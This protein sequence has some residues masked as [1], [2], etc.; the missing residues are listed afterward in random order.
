[1]A[2]KHETKKLSSN[3]SSEEME[4]RICPSRP[5]KGKYKSKTK[6]RSRRG[7]RQEQPSFFKAQG[8]RPR[9]VGH[10]LIDFKNKEGS[11][12][13]FQ[14]IEHFEISEAID[15]CEINHSYCQIE[16]KRVLSK[17]AVR[18]G[19]QDSFERSGQFFVVQATEGLE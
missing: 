7:K 16:S 2:E 17:N 19:F 11:P 5:R 14:E 4:E 18:N 15:W 9:V 8:R 12:E 13:W 10:F 6:K 3:Y 1:M